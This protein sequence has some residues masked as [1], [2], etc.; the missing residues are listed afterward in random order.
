M[1]VVVMAMMIPTA[2]SA[3]ALEV[4]ILTLTET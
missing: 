3:V 2:A 4:S 1:M